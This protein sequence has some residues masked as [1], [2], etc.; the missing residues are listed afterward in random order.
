MDDRE[1]SEEVARLRAALAEE[2]SKTEA[3]A[4]L[5][6]EIR[7]LLNGVLGITGLLLETDLGPEQRA[8]A[9]QIRSAG[10][11]L[12]GIVNNVLDYSRFDAGKVE[13][14]RVDFD[15]RRLVE[16]VGALL[17]ER[18]HARGVELIVA[19]ASNLPSA[20]RGDPTRLRQVLINLVSNAIKFTSEGEVVLKAAPVGDSGDSA[21]IRFE[22][23]DTGVGISPEGQAKLFRP[24][25]QVHGGGGY[26]G[27]GLGLA[28]TK[29]LVEAMGGNIGV[30][31]DP[32]RGSTFWCAIPFERRAPPTERSSIPRVDVAGRRVLV[33]STSSTARLQIREIV[34]GLGIECSLAPD[35]ER[36][37]RL[38]REAGRALRP[39]DVVMVDANL[40]ELDAHAL[41]RAIHAEDPLTLVRV[42]A[43]TYPGQRIPDE[44]VAAHVEKPIRQA[45]LHACLMTLLGSAVE[46]IGA[47][48]AKW[49]ESPTSSSRRSIS[50][51][52]RGP[53]P[54]RRGS[55]PPPSAVEAS[56]AADAA[57]DAPRVLL[58]EDNE[59]NQKVAR[60]MVERRGYRVD[61]ANDGIEA[62]AATEKVAYTAILMDCQMP[63]F[64]GY[65]ATVMIRTREGAAKHTP[66]IAMTA[67]AGPG[68]REK[69]FAA[70][71]DDYVSK[72]I[73][74]DELDRVLRR[75]APRAAPAK[76]E[77]PE[78]RSSRPP[79]GSPIDFDM[80]ERLRAVQ[81][82]GQPDLVAEVITLF[83]EDA[84]LRLAALREAVARG[85]LT[86]AGRLAHTIKGSAG[87]LGAKT[88]SAICG[89][90]EEKVRK[91]APFNAVFAVTAVEEELERVRAALLAGD[92][93]DAAAGEQPRSSPA[94]SRAPASGERPSAPPDRPITAPMAPIAPGRYADAPASGGDDD[95]APP[96]SRRGE[97]RAAAGPSSK[98][99]PR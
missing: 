66:I 37:L 74:A 21:Q 73:I 67:N 16:E 88:L 69:C 15:L 7:T 32:G 94:A 86:L 51:E 22:V 84:P 18:A 58:V 62:V 31:S 45:Q 52:G 33:A 14:D 41:I 26:G 53:P 27:S 97:G 77:T 78:R 36:A 12:V 35:A 8:F 75:W 10:D 38:V 48:D 34:G 29:R 1:P 44:R 83:L 25:T 87:H 43:A 4:H 63:R 40:G 5:N 93:R 72:P 82:E 76:A 6:H 64:D 70:G 90:F 99:F 80:L 39:F 98:R 23:T 19:V 55:M 3:F 24:F 91:G 81:R 54:S 68:E 20:L 71:M 11:A 57:R 60:V 65:S 42:I 50:T 13:L 89:R 17:A 30:T 85:D 46:A 56:A 95:A 47:M 96:S 9:K 2:Q 61:V 79:R 28:L 92:G 49:Q 59:V